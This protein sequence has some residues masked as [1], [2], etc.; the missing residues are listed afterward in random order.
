MGLVQGMLFDG[1]EREKQGRAD[2][3]AAFGRSRESRIGGQNLQFA[4]LR[5]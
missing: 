5:L 3:V 4:R 1:E 2:A